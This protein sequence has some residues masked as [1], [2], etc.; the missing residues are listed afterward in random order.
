MRTETC[1]FLGGTKLVIEPL[2]THIAYRCPDCGTVV[3][4][5]VGRFA[6]SAGL[7][8]LKCHCGNSAA[9]ITV[10]QDGKVRL[11]VPCLFCRQN[12]SFVVSQSIFFGRDIFLLNCPYSNMD[13][14]FIGEKEKCDEQI[15][16]TAEELAQLL[17]N[18]E[19]EKLSDIQPQDVD[20]EEVLPDPTVYDAM[21]FLV[22][23]LEYDGKIDCPCHGGSY[24]LRFCREGIQVYCPT[25][26]ATH[27]F[28]T[29]AEAAAE[30]YLDTDSITLS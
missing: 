25:C 6:L 21:R 26:G 4:G 11:S 13:I 22:K 24:E 28:D 3:Y 2:K 12:H 1:A 8:R 20:E 30:A 18:L 27:T 16:R 9:D 15:D 17:T 19:A 29:R 7:I 14:C 5:F 23:E 10:T